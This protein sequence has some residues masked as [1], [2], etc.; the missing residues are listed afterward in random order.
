MIAA[1]RV[2]THINWMVHAIRGA[3]RWGLENEL[4][5]PSV[6]E[7]LRAVAPLKAGRSKARESPPVRPVPEGAVEA[8]LPHLPRVVQAM[9]RLQLLTGARPGEIC[10]IKPGEITL[11]TDG[12]W[13][14]RPARH[15]GSWRGKERRVFIG[16]KGQE[17]LRPFLDRPSDQC[18]FR[19]CDSEAERNAAK[20][21]GRK[22]PM[23]P[24][25][26]LR[27]ERANKNRTR[28]PGEM[29]EKEAY[30]I[31]IRRAC[32][33]AGVEPWSPNQLRHSRATLLR[34]LYGIE[35]ARL[36][37]GHADAGIT[38]V[39]AERDFDAAAKIMR[40]IG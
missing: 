39:Y 14:Y 32:K 34:K 26:R 40:E 7:S 35:A 22:T 25:Q 20:R 11:G 24:S 9:V 17:I 28:P 33:A 6:V 13:S 27:A 19:P 16:P 5:P 2:R 8:T 38:L 15:K 37:L 23:T 10:A 4:V 3:F 12:T 18:C 31:A 1:G 21:E 36:V 30:N 29:Y